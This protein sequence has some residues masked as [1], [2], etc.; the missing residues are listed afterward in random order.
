M[1]APPRRLRWPRRR[2]TRKPTRAASAARPPWPT[3]PAACWRAWTSWSSGEGAGR[4]ARGQFLRASLSC[5][6]GD[7]SGV[8]RARERPTGGHVRLVRPGVWEPGVWEPRESEIEVTSLEVRDGGTAS[9][10]LPEP[11]GR[12]SGLPKRFQLAH[13]LVCICTRG[14]VERSLMGMVRFFAPDTSEP[15]RKNPGAH[16]IARM[17]GGQDK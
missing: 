3:A 12:R 13:N 5:P 7:A 10:E 9:A 15:K 6:R 4:G 8:G 2:S 17:S 16:R 1:A 14:R 11:S